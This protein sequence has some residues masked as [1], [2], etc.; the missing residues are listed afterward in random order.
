MVGG[1]RP[2][3]T[4]VDVHAIE[5]A[6]LPSR[7]LRWPPSSGPAPQGLARESAKRPLPCHLLASPEECA[8][9]RGR[10]RVVVR[11]AAI[12]WRC[13]QASTALKG[14]PAA[15]TITR[16]RRSATHP[17]VAPDAGTTH[18]LAVAEADV[19]YDQL[20]EMDVIQPRIFRAPIVGDR[21]GR[22]RRGSTRAKSDPTRPPVTA[23]ARSAWRVDQ[24]R[25]VFRGQRYSLGSGY[26][27]IPAT[28]C[29]SA[30][31]LNG[32]SGRC[33]AVASWADPE[34][35][36]T[37]VARLPVGLG[38]RASYAGPQEVGQN[39]LQPISVQPG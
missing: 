20:F 15:R 37:R 4:Q 19:A 34:P 33:Q 9:P 14:R 2:V 22:Q 13:A 17:R 11:A 36:R 12:A 25:S 38:G 5:P 21:S 28:T 8:S 6:S 1:R 32:V 31:D 3:L 23:F 30:P 39:R 26:C 7:A 27:R 10:E 29:L 24:P 16:R 35:A 18:E